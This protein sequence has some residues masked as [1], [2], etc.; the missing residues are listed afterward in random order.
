MLPPGLVPVEV[1]GGG[2]CQ[3]LS[4]LDQLRLHLS[5]ADLRRLESPLTDLEVRGMAVDGLEGLVASGEI[6]QDV[7]E[8]MLEEFPGRTSKNI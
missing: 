1:G 4:I 3:F 5:E 2:D 8:A 7:I 6:R